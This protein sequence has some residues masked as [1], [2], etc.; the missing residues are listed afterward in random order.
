VTG[1][2]SKIRQMGLGKFIKEGAHWTVVPSK[3]KMK[4]GKRKKRRKEK[5][6][7]KR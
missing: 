2:R 4:K 5:K 6:K 7:R 3:K 1:K